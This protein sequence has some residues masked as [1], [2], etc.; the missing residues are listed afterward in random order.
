MLLATVSSG[1]K[2]S[3]RHIWEVLMSPISPRNLRT[4][5][6]LTSIYQLVSDNFHLCK[7]LCDR[8]TRWGTAHGLKL[9]R[10]RICNPILAIDCAAASPK[11]QKLRTGYAKPYPTGHV[12]TH[13]RRQFSASPP[14]NE[15]RMNEPTAQCVCT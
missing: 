2:W 7:L 1:G 13:R 12:R 4:T 10:K 8:C 15:G 11:I 14:P 5:A 9:A 6:L 3:C